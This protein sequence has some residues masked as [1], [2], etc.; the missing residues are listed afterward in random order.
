L[1]EEAVQLRPNE[2]SEILLDLKA[3][4]DQAYTLLASLGGDT[5]PYK[6]GLH[7]LTA[8]LMAAVQ[9][10]AAG[11]LLAGEELAQEQM[12][13]RQHYH[14]LEYPLVADLMRPDSPVKGEE[15]VATLLSAPRD[16]LDAALWLFA[17]EELE[18]LCREARALLT[19]AG[20]EQGREN[21]TAME[22]YLVRV[23]DS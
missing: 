5:A 15:L 20:T 12:A 21:L 23:G 16:E 6:Q 9:R 19:A 14:L 10:A 4:L 13:R 22:S 2:E 8:T 1:L 11:D 18:P 3:R 7:R 17:Q